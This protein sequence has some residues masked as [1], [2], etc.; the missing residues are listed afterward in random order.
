MHRTLEKGNEIPYWKVHA[1]R[2]NDIIGIRIIL[3]RFLKES[4]GL[5]GE[6]L[7]KLEEQVADDIRDF[8]RR[9]I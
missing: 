3:D 1:N 8:M 7:R 2:A 5:H 9:E 6:K 4:D